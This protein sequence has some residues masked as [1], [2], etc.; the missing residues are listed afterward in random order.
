MGDWKVTASRLVERKQILDKLDLTSA[1][2]LI[3]KETFDNI[4]KHFTERADLIF[5]G[6]ISYNADPE[7]MTTI[8]KEDVLKAQLLQ[9]EITQLL[10]Q[11]NINVVFKRKD[12]S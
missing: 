6:I 9:D 4:L 1:E 12:S 7:G 11:N 8:S 3:Q 2:Y 5:S 10:K